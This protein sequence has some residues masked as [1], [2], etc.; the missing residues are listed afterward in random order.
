MNGRT[1]VGSPGYLGS[2]WFKIENALTCCSLMERCLTQPLC[3]THPNSPPMNRNFRYFLKILEKVPINPQITISSPGIN[4][5]K[6]AAAGL[7]T[8][9]QLQH[10]WSVELSR[11]PPTLP[12]S[13]LT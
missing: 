13:Q 10:L 8:N 3:C 2:K 5:H 11:Y 1:M 7:G 12:P 9:N 4:P 6:M